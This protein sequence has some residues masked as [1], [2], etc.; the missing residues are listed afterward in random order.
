MTQK[1]LCFQIETTSALRPSSFQ[2][3]V[4]IWKI[5]LK[6]IVSITRGQEEILFV[7]S[8]L[9]KNTSY[10]ASLGA[11]LIFTHTYT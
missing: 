5:A 8:S 6:K 2:K 4:A 9:K 11:L 10:N 7:P 1:V 3:S